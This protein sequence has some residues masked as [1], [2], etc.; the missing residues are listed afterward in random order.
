MNQRTSLRSTIS[1]GGLALATVVA[2]AAC[3]VSEVSR[4]VNGTTVSPEP[5]IH[6]TDIRP[7]DLDEALLE[8]LGLD[9]TDFAT[10]S[11]TGPTCEWGTSSLE[12]PRL[13]YWVE[14]PSEPDPANTVVTVADQP[15]EVFVESDVT[16]A[17]VLR[18]E[19]LTFTGRYFTDKPANNES[20]AAD[21]AEM[22][23]S[24]LLAQYRLP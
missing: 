22:V 7:C 6:R 17:Y 2:S 9:P 11:G 5:E 18:F 23:V 13:Q 10:T 12:L 16:A 14:G 3:S 21:G 19:E 15:A 8:H 24:A 20:S 1:A 4:T